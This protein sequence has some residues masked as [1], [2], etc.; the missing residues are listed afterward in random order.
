[1]TSHQG[2]T[3]DQ[4]H[5]LY[6]GSC[7]H[8]QRQ[9]FTTRNDHC[10]AIRLVQ[11]VSASIYG[12][13]E[14]QLI[15]PPHHLNGRWIT[16]SVNEMNQRMF[17]LLI[18]GRQGQLWVEEC[19]GRK[20]RQGRISWMEHRRGTCRYHHYRICNWKQQVTRRTW[21]SDA[22]QHVVFSF[23]LIVSASVLSWLTHLTPSILGP[24][25]HS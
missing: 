14:R 13:V 6:A 8:C 17:P 7:R 22:P 16:E 12:K 1:M 4:S 2:V 23:S 25:F 3:I 19:T 15:W 9:S 18:R 11:P 20:S 5:C 21:R 24:S 10:L